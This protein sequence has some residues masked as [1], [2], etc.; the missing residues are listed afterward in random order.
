[1]WSGSYPCEMPWRQ[2]QHDSWHSG[3]FEADNTVP[4]P[5][6]DLAA[7]V[8]YQ[9][10]GYTAYLTWDLSVNDPYS[11]DPEEPADVVS[12]QVYR[13]FPPDGYSL[14]SRTHA[15]DGFYTDVCI[16]PF[17][18]LVRYVVTSDD[19]VNESGYSNDV[20]FRTAPGTN[21][22]LGCAVREEREH[23]GGSATAS[24]G[25]DAASSRLPVTASSEPIE[26][27][28]GAWLLTD[29]ETSEV[30]V[31][32]PGVSTVVIDLGLVC[33]ITG[34]SV[35]SG[36]GST[37]AG[38]TSSSIEVSRDGS[39]WASV[40]DCAVMSGLTGRYVRISPAPSATEVFVWGD[41]S[42]EGSTASIGI[43][44]SDGR[45]SLELPVL[46]DASS[47]ETGTLSVYDV[48]GRVLRSWTVRPGEE[49]DWDGRTA[50]GMQVSPGCCFVRYEQGGEAVTRRLM[51]TAE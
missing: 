23:R 4:E 43:V 17:G 15:G 11:G 28:S 40:A 27:H 38:S 37:T 25:T 30:Y 26:E 20:R 14:L 8:T 39:A 51:V 44:R 41:A 35:E 33:G 7:S 29:G 31:P 3:C 16:S 13:S 48:T 10:Y 46:D 34:V 49:V 36:E 1:M 47:G 18:G 24:V 2:F 19:G 12:Y 22:A 6:T 21:L 50:S 5:P 45:W 32:G 9:M 42:E